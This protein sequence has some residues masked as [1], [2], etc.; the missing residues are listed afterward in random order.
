VSVNPPPFFPVNRLHAA[1]LGLLVTCLS[2]AANAQGRACVD[3]AE[4]A[5]ELRVSG[6][7]R[8]ARLEL[9]KCAK[10]E[11]PALVATDCKT[12]LQQVEATAPRVVV[13]ASS[14][15][16]KATTEVTVE[17]NDVKVADSIT[18]PILLNPGELVLRLSNGVSPPIERRLTLRLGQTENVTVTFDRPT[19]PPT[20][21]PPAPGPLVVEVPPRSTSV[22]VLPIALAAL[23]VVGVSLFTVLAVQ[24][25]GELRGYDRCKPFCDRSDVEA[26]R[27]RL[28]IGDI[29]LGAGIV[30]LGVAAWL[31]LSD[32]SVGKPRSAQLGVS[33]NR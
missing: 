12:W 30:A 9:M 16:G 27:T 5:Q 23:G 18:E 22:P 10:R 6:Q 4:R 8:E 33:P 21:A 2:P 25:T 11:C 32:R 28:V 24:G 3:A 15:D 17:S 20:P 14:A 1:M 7:L 29:S 26:T 31:Y 13:R 19:P